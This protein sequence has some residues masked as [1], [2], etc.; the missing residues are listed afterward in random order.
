MTEETELQIIAHGKREWA[1]LLTSKD[2]RGGIPTVVCHPLDSR[3]AAECALHEIGSNQRESGTP[4]GPS[5][6]PL[7]YF[8][9]LGRVL[10][11]LRRSGV[12]CDDQIAL[13][14]RI[15]HAASR[16]AECRQ[17]GDLMDDELP[18]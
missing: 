9:A 6:V 17:F 8:N 16:A 14:T 1:V 7:G 13:V 15:A 10:S 11:E 3:E 18:F 5:E 12:E 2:H 4:Y